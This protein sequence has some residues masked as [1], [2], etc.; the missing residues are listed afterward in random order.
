VKTPRFKVGV[1]ITSPSVR[2]ELDQ[3]ISPPGHFGVFLALMLLAV[4]TNGVHIT[5][6]WCENK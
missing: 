6:Y 4:V 2:R 5:G 3:A 1:P